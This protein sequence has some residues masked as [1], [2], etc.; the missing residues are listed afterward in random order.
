MESYAI[1]ILKRL[2]PRM[3]NKCNPLLSAVGK[4]APRIERNSSVFC[5]VLF[6]IHPNII[7]NIFFSPVC[8]V[9]CSCQTQLLKTEQNKT[10]R[11]E[12]ILKRMIN[13]VSCKQTLI[14]TKRTWMQ[15]E[16]TE[17]VLYTTK[18]KR[19]ERETKLK[20]NLKYIYRQWFTKICFNCDTSCKLR[21]NATVI[22]SIF[23]VWIYKRFG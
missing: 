10:K 21:A 12:W 11:N 8:L 1:Q 20:N 17:K 6:P 15:N 4:R 18:R 13:S 7:C 3:R 2:V 22:H 5:D 16:G 9:R 23:D 14:K 19:N